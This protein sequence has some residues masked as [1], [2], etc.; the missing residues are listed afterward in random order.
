MFIYGWGRQ[1]RNEFGPLFMR[2]CTHC[3][4]EQYWNLSS[5]SVWFTIFFIPVIPYKFIR[6]IYCPVCSYGFE[7]DSDKF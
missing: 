4:N 7:L 6:R 2:L 5:V 1:I 3:N